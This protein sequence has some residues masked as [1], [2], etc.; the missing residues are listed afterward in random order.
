MSKDV[1][2]KLRAVDKF[3]STLDR[4]TRK[5]PKMNKRIRQSNIAFKKME[6][7]TRTLRN[8]LN[9]TGKKMRSVGKNMTMSVTAPIVAMGAVILNTNKNFQKSFNKV[10]AK[11]KVVGKSFEDLKNQAREM[12]KKGT[13]SAV[14]TADAM[15]FLAQ[16]GFRTNEI[17][18]ATP[19]VLNLAA[20]AGEDLAQT[21][22]VMSNVM[23]AFG[24]AKDMANSKKA[25][26]IMAASLGGANIDLTQFAD[27]MKFAA[28]IAKS[29]GVNMADTAAAVGL[30]GN[31]GIQGSVAATALK[32]VFLGLSAPTSSAAKALKTIGVEVADSNGKLRP[33]ITVLSELGTKIHDFPQV[34]KMKVLKELFG[35]KGIAGASVL[36]TE[37]MN[38]TDTGLK[39][40]AE[41]LNNSTGAAE[42]MAKVTQKG[43]PLALGKI[44][45][46]FEAVLL[47][48]GIEGGLNGAFIALSEKIVGFLGWIEKLN[49]TVLKWGLIIAGVVAA[50]G[51]LLIA[52]GF[53]LPAISALIT[54]FGFLIPIGGAIMGAFSSIVGVFTALAPLASIIMTVLGAISA[55]VWG[56]VAAVAALVAAVIRVIQKWSELKSAFSSGKG[57]I[58]TMKKMG[59]VFFGVGDDTGA[60]KSNTNAT[61]VNQ[62]AA[63]NSV[64]TNNSKVGVDFSNLPQGAK[65]KTENVDTTNIAFAGFQA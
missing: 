7:Q 17:F 4:V 52:F 49:P 27:T 54:G 65:V 8:S 51:P 6:R 63:N 41:R 55:P 24:L 43:L 36:L 47:T 57:F 19:H 13:F 2:I 14:Q 59:S 10:E 45:G 58:D 15:A 18:A 37:A 33:M 16:A 61:Q 1:K 40:F 29:Y 32:S 46:A 35:K 3:S 42:R 62:T 31:V 39:K 5:I 30:L 28:P 12:G 53:M 60:K 26:D 22:D 11:A 56:T 48:L 38:G 44:T 23:G 9:R 34:T 20:A 21:A 64:Q 50:V 25:A